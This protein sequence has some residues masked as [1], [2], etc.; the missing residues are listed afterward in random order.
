MLPHNE[1][2]SRSQSPAEQ[3]HR[4]ERAG[5]HGR[6]RYPTLELVASVYAVA[7]VVLLA[8][9]AMSAIQKPRIDCSLRS[10]PY[11]DLACPFAGVEN[12]DF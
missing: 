8:L 7:M 2:F 5:T 3:K 6:R 1:D 12:R 11:S 9:T 10:V 4:S